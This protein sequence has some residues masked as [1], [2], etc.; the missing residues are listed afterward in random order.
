MQACGAKKDS[1]SEDQSDTDSRDSEESQEITSRGSVRLQPLGKKK[2]V[3]I[4]NQINTTARAKN[5]TRRF[6]GFK[7]R[8]AK[9]ARPVIVGQVMLSPTGSADWRRQLQGMTEA[10]AKGEQGIKS[11][12]R[13]QA[14]SSTRLCQRT[15]RGP[16]SPFHG[17]VDTL[18]VALGG[19]YIALGTAEDPTEIGDQRPPCHHFPSP[20]V[21]STRALHVGFH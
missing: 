17:S 13:E 20:I 2:G 3:K 4:C 9:G 10:R 16:I 18:R 11:N 15:F 5:E 12:P 6:G 19:V 7:L 14:E 8:G 21:D 1:S